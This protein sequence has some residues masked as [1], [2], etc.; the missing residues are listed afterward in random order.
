MKFL[1]VFREAQATP[2]MLLAEVLHVS[3]KPNTNTMIVQLEVPY[4]FTDSEKADVADAISKAYGGV[5][6]KVEYKVKSLEKKESPVIYGRAIKDPVIEKISNIDQYY[7]KVTIEGQIINTDERETKR[8]KI[9][10][11]FDVTDKSSSITCKLI[12]TKEE[13]ERVL[14]NLK[15]GKYITLQGEAGY[16]R[17]DNEV[18]IF[19]D[20]IMKANPP[21]YKD[22]VE[23]ARVEL[24]LHTKM[25]AMDSVIETDK[26]IERAAQ[27][28]QKAIAITDHGVVQSF[29]DALDAG[30]KY[31][32]KILYGVECYLIDDSVKILSKD[33]DASFS[34]TLVAIDIETTSLSPLTGTIIE[35]GAVKIK[36][37]QIIESFSE[38]VDPGKAIGETTTNLTGITNDMLVGKR[39]IAEVMLDFL[40]FIGD[41]PLIAHNANFDYNFVQYECEKLGYSLNNVYVDTLELSKLAFDGLKKFKLDTIAKHL[42]INMGSH[43]RATDDANTCGMIFIKVAEEMKNE[44]YTKLSDFN[45]KYTK[46]DYKKVNSYHAVILVKNQAGMKNLYK[47]ISESHLNYFYKRPRVP[48]RIL[49]MYREGLIV[50]SACEAGELYNAVISGASHDKLLE[51]AS[52]YDYLEIQ[53]LGNN[54]FMIDNGTVSSMEEIKG[55]NKMIVDLAKEQDKLYV[56]TCDAHFLDPEDKIYRAI[57]Q[58][59]Q[60]YD[61]ADRQAP[62]YFRSTTQMLKEF[63][64][65]DEET[66]YNA[67]VTNTNLI[68]DMIEA[69]LQPIPKKQYAPRIEGAED[70]VRNITY[71]TAHE[72]Y[73]DRMPQFVIDRIEKELNSIINNGFSVMYVIAQKLVWKS[74]ADGYLVGSRGSVGSS[75]VAFLMKITE[76]NSLCPHYVCPKCKYNEFFRNGEIACGIDLPDKL[77]PECGTPLYKDGHDIPFETFLGF[78]GEKDPDIDLNFSGEYQSKIHKYTEEL[79]GE[80][81]VFKAGTISTL[82]DKTAYGYVV[83]YLQEREIVATNAE[84]NRLTLG[85]AGVKKTTGQH[86]GGMVVVPSD[87]DIYDFCPIHRPADKDDADFITT[88]FD[89]SK[90]KG[91]LLKLDELGHDD[92]TSLRMLGDITGVDVQKIPLDDK[93]VMSLFH[94]NEALNY[95]PEY[96]EGETFIDVVGTYAIPEFGTTF[97]R[98]MLIDTQ[99]STFSE[100]IRISG[101]SHGT[102]VW[103]GN[104]QELVKAGTATLKEVICT[105][106]DIMVNLMHMGMESKDA[107]D[108]MEFTRKGKFKQHKD[109]IPKMEESN[110]PQWYID[111]C[112]KISYM[113]PKAH[114]AAYV[115]MAFRI[116]WFKVYKPIAFYQTYFT[117]RA[118][119][120]DSTIMTKGIERTRDEIR[121]LRNS[122]EKLSATNQS[123]LTILEV[124]NEMYTRGYKF[125]PVDLYE[126]DAKVFLEKDGS[127]LPPLNA[128]AGLGENAAIAIAEARKNGEFLSIEDLR[129]RSGIN[130]TALEVLRQEGCLDGMEESDQIQ[131]F[132]F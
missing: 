70:D 132:T 115:T 126:S 13:A 20:A 18:G 78:H 47:I 10:F 11:K 29:P 32:V 76:V 43:H 14:P 100:L 68:A 28:G 50:G 119:L 89:Y 57:I 31:G 51:I 3:L 12:L 30:K 99:P 101:L 72:I 39:K 8:G 95:L 96:M 71:N 9:L 117:V 112:L 19:A 121:K 109:L 94:S 44:G 91:T 97:V 80:G 122:D 55:F 129:L 15:S 5:T 116:A 17:Y 42:N 88:H 83:K 53:P 103:L 82:A 102:N 25:S 66:A 104:A 120:F 114:A 81:F 92:P 125:L 111:S 59:G 37:G 74:V 38:L 118:D 4:E 105:R 24:H 77:C 33:T 67:V 110:V 40:K 6:V 85:C 87:M 113:F 107:F 73:G 130:K 60:G 123:I 48:K 98:Q 93:K 108:I 86:P 36:D 61:D 79:F 124:V 56:A 62:L 69:D 63:D 22:D 131:F 127:I 84:K 16:D 1:E 75:F 7:G 54:R 49:D 27:W 58:A 35:F 128:M 45:V 2:V 23:K 90:M 21:V 52:Y 46:N 41:A 26:V 34:D 65:L 64:Y 106:D